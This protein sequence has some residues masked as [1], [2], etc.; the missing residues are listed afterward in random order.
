MAEF[1][2]FPS[3]QCKPTEPS[4]HLYPAAANFLIDDYIKPEWYKG[5]QHVNLV[6]IDELDCQDHHG[7]VNYY[8]NTCFRTVEKLYT[9][10][11]EVEQTFR[12]VGLCEGF[13]FELQCYGVVLLH[14]DVI[15]PYFTKE[16]ISCRVLLRK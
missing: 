7:V 5:C 14:R 6:S 13:P 12:V 1:P 10:Q 9:F 15:P 11:L 3:Y 4:N 8:I 2:P 16:T